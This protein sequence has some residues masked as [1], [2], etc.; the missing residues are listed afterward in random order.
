[1][2]TPT[3]KVHCTNGSCKRWFHDEKSLQVH[4][5]TCD[6]KDSPTSRANHAR[7][8]QNYAKRNHITD[9]DDG[10]GEKAEE[11]EEIEEETPASPPT[12]R[13]TPTKKKVDDGES[14][15][16]EEE[17]GNKKGIKRKVVEVAEEEDED[18]DGMPATK[19]KEEVPIQKMKHVSKKI[20]ISRPNG[21]EVIARFDDAGFRWV[22]EALVTGGV[23]ELRQ[24][25]HINLQEHFEDLKKLE[26][27][28]YDNILAEVLAQED[29]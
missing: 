1:M 2:A 17:E 9:E 21:K 8:L 27:E 3:K 4:K 24:L 16:E 11:E 28:A 29:A 19:G 23:V 20:K 6:G 12:R 7:Y 15:N 25:P 10:A 14:N 22:G 5:T 18:E 13:T 26:Q